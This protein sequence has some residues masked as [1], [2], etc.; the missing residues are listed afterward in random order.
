TGNAARLIVRPEHEVI[1]EELR[2]APEEIRE[3]SPSFLG[4]EPVVLVHANPRQFLAPLR[5]LIALPCQRLFRIEQLEP[6]PKPFFTRSGL[7]CGHRHSPL[8]L[9]LRV[10]LR[11]GLGSVGVTSVTGFRWTR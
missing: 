2:A 8:S 1:D 6:R 5:E 4:V 3:R 9:P 11:P 10:R 7:V